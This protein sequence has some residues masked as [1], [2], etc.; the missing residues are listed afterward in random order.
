MSTV[1][2]ARRAPEYV[3]IRHKMEN[4]KI[5]DLNKN[6]SL[7][8]DIKDGGYDAVH[9]IDY[10]AEGWI[11]T[12]CPELASVFLGNHPAYSLVTAPD[13]FPQCEQREVM[14]WWN[15]FVPKALREDI[16]QQ[17]GPDALS[18][19]RT[20]ANL[21]LK[22]EVVRGENTT[23]NPI[24][25]SQDDTM[26]PI[27]SLP[28]KIPPQNTK[29]GKLPETTRNSYLPDAAAGVFAPGWDV[30]F[31]RTKEGTGF[32]AAYGLGSPFLEDSK[33]CAALSTFW[34]A[35]APDAART[36]GPNVNQSRFFATVSP[37]TDEEIG[38]VGNLPWD[39]VSGPIHKEG[40]KLIEYTKFDYVDYVNNALH[41]NFSLSLTSRIGI[42]E[43]QDRILMM[44]RVYAA[45]GITHDDKPNWGVLSFREVNLSD[46]ELRTAQENTHS[47]NFAAAT[48]RGTVY[49]FEMYLRGQTLSDEN[50][51]R[52][53]HV[54]INEKVTLFV[55]GVQILIKREDSDCILQDVNF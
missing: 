15:Q 50:D 48:S 46:E 23:Q 14:D 20:A 28:Y 17:G 35:V 40:Q 51:F 26:T 37:L 21:E 9:Y 2:K 45:L 44:A 19:T 42:R 47:L 7:M 10:T 12:I 30:S 18:D 3:H 11:E 6:S 41:K 4:G 38:Q 29:Y 54:E 13:F 16:W 43:Y 1:N 34:P 33:L 52:K 36:F 39:G 5:I 49:R 27:V 8:K 32:L 24:F 31:D 25:N 55:N 53:V 22:K